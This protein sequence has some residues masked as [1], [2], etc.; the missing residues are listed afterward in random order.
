MRWIP[1]FEA[2]TL[3]VTARRD[4]VHSNHSPASGHLASGYC[5]STALPAASARLPALTP[6]AASRIPATTGSTI[7]KVTS[8]QKANID[9]GN[10]QASRHGFGQAWGLL[11]QCL[12]GIINSRAPLLR[13]LKPSG[14]VLH[15]LPRRNP[16]FKH[17]TRDSHR[18]RRQVEDRGY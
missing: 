4:V 5:L 1:P 12:G 11:L 15:S 9:V 3:S 10:H 18:R 2:F 17:E 7:S 6:V 14:E 8:A 13:R 16:G